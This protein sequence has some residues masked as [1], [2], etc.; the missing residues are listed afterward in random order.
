M[1][2]ATCNLVEQA[3]NE[4]FS[5]SPVEPIQSVHITAA[6]PQDLMTPGPVDCGTFLRLYYPSVHPISET[7]AQHSLWPLWAEDEY[8]VGFVKFMQAVLARW[9]SWAPR[10]EFLCIDQVAYLA[11]VMHLGCT[12]MW[13]LLNGKVY[14]PI[15]RNAPI[16]TEKQWPVIVFSHGMGCSRFAYSR[17]CTDLASH[18]FLVA[19]VEH[20]DASAA[21]SFTMEDGRRKWIPFRRVLDSEKE[22]TVRNSQLLQRVEEVKRSL[23]VVTSLAGGQAVTNVLLEAEQFDLAMFA[24]RLDLSRPVLAGHSYGGATTLMA[25]AR[26]NRFHHGL[27]LDGW[28]FPLKEEQINPAQP[29]VFINTESFMN[30]DNIAKMKTFLRDKDQDRRLI[31]IKGSVHQN[32]IDAPLIFKAGIL[33]RIMGFQSETDPVLV[34]DLND[35]LML[36]FIWSHLGLE[37]DGEVVAFLEQHGDVLVEATDESI[38]GDDSELADMTKGVVT[39]IVSEKNEYVEKIDETKN[40]A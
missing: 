27:V 5:S 16:S 34:L 8:L 40:V 3:R 26:D 32:H 18:G 19:A 10:G 29:I 23:D 15:L 4:P 33:K 13:R 37:V 2:V 24:D 22:Y 20:R 21:V 28:L 17:L 9:P 12:H 38:A 14:C 1:L 31:F 25:L 6:P 7:V 35:K 11:P 39:E 36:H 30:R